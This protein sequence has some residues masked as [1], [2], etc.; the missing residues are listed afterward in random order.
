M[1]APE[2][3][4]MCVKKDLST[5]KRDL[6]TPKRDLYTPKRDIRKYVAHPP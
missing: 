2:T 6:S 1:L 4:N 3:R 5:P